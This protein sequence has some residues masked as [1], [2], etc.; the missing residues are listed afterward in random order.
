ME[1]VTRKTLPKFPNS[2]RGD[3]AFEYDTQVWMERNQKRTT[4]KAIEFLFDE[5]LGKA[6][7]LKHFPYLILDLGCGSGF[8]SEILIEQG[9]RVIGIDLL[10][11]M[12]SKS[13]DKKKKHGYQNLELI[14]GDI[15]NIPL[16]YNSIDHIIS[17]SAYN[18][19][20][21]KHKGPTNSKKVINNTARNLNKILKKDGRLIIE[22]YPENDTELKLFVNS[23]L[24]NDFNGY[25]IKSNPKQKSGQTFLCLIKER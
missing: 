18:F 2:Y 16:R 7:I 25:M 15:N 8:S 20:I 17:I 6:N 5:K 1:A 23:F 22:F 11:D 24:L 10:L 21:F 13:F 9:F 3:K 14:L 19:I 12:L 4:L